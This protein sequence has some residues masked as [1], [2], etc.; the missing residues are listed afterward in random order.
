MRLEYAQSTLEVQQR[1]TQA[2]ASKRL[3][4]EDGW[5]GQKQWELAIMG[6]GGKSRVAKFF[7][8]DHLQAYNVL[9]CTLVKENSI[10][11]SGPP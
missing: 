5:A 10:N 4:E 3:A 11:L 6:I 7:L 2:G 8:C 1:D 9:F